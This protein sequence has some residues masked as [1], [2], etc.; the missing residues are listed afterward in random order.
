MDAGGVALVGACAVALGA[1]VTAVGVILSAKISARSQGRTQHSH[2]R[3]QV[4][5]DA[6]SAFLSEVHQQQD[7]LGTAT[8]AFIGTGRRLELELMLSPAPMVAAGYTVQLEGPDAVNAAARDLTAAFT[9]WAAVLLAHAGPDDLGIAQPQRD[10]F[11]A[12]DLQEV[13]DMAGVAHRQFLDSARQ[14]L[15]DSSDVLAR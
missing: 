5:R 11:R 9:C 4:R 13:A 7:R 2:W 14:A 15:D 1:V 10:V 3:R 12:I 6:Y 8:Q